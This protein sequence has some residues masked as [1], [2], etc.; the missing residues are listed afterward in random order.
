LIDLPVS[1]P[2]QPPGPYAIHLQALIGDAFTNP[3]SIKVE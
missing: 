2:E 3:W 1:I